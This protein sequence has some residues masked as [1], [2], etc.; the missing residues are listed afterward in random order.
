[1]LVTGDSLLLMPGPLD[2]PRLEHEP[3]H[4]SQELSDFCYSVVD[5]LLPFFFLPLNPVQNILRVCPAA[6][7]ADNET[8]F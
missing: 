8:L 7:T 2:F 6:D 1:M 4:Q 5:K 3:T